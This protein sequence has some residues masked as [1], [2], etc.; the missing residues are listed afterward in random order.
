MLV[1]TEVSWSVFDN[2]GRG[3]DWGDGEDATLASVEDVTEEWCDSSSTTYAMGP[4]TRQWRSMICVMRLAR[5]VNLAVSGC[6]WAKANVSETEDRESFGRGGIE[7]D[8]ETRLVKS[9]I[10]EE[11]LWRSTLDKIC[12]R[13]ESSRRCAW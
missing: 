13:S 10:G 3:C 8:M 7:G 5:S 11:A 9:S 1:G 12:G 6:R 4:H 2:D